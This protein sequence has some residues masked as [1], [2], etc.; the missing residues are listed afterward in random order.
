MRFNQN[1][2]KKKQA[3]TPPKPI[4]AKPLIPK[5][6]KTIVTMAAS[7]EQLNVNLAPEWVNSAQD[8]IH[9]WIAQRHFE[10]ALKLIT[11]CEEYF[12]K[13]NSFA[14]SVEIISKV[15]VIKLA[16]KIVFVPIQIFFSPF[17]R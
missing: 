5:P 8:E 14:N 6:T 4:P 7:T 15:S 13:N 2:K 12:V 1:Q 11:K 9:T 17:L 16:F 3:P 10:D